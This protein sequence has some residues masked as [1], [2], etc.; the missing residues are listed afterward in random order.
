MPNLP[1]RRSLN[2]HEDAQRNTY[3]QGITEM[4]VKTA[5]EALAAYYQGLHS[6]VLLL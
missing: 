2:L 3:A 6:I 4:E 5:N 1:Y